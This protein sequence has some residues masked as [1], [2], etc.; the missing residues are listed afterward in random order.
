M[1]AM[2]A[3]FCLLAVTA[4]FLII[5]QNTRAD[6]KLSHSHAAVVSSSVLY[7]DLLH[8]DTCQKT[9]F[10]QHAPAHHCLSDADPCVAAT[11]NMVSVCGSFV[12][13]VQNDAKLLV[14]ATDAQIK[15]AASQGVQPSTQ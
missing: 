3:A 2:R 9:S 1:H 10:Q 14:A 12:T 15:D 8:C 7:H 13:K 6:G 5:P 4:V 11:L